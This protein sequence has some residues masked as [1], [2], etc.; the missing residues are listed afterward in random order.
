MVDALRK[1][2]R[3]V[4]HPG[5]VVD[6]HPTDALATLFVG[7]AMA[8]PV[9]TG[10]ATARHRA[11]S[12][13]IA[14]TAGDGL[15]AIDDRTEFD[16]F[17]YGDSIQELQDHIMKDWRQARIGDATLTRALVLLRNSKS[18]PRVRERVVMTRLLPGA[19]R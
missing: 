16:F 9:D 8:G 19:G 7:G 14:L 3:F 15:F 12:R 10:D 5:C 17:T 11:A 1:A 2:E 6:I 13:A 18:K 4:T